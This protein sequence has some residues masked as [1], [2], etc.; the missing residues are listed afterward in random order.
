[1]EIQSSSGFVTASLLAATISISKHALSRNDADESRS[2]D[3]A[4][5]RTSFQLVLL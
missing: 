3:A 1:M 4:V 5:R 2:T